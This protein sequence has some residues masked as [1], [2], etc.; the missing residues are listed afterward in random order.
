MSSD[1][2][3]F[4]VILPNY[5]LPNIGRAVQSILDQ[6]RADWELLVLCGGHH[7]GESTDDRLAGIPADPRIRRLTAVEPDAAA[8]V[9][10]AYHDARGQWI[11]GLD[12]DSHWYP[13]CLSAFADT[14][15][16]RPEAKFVFGDMDWE[17]NGRIQRAV[18]SDPNRPLT[19]AE[20]FRRGTPAGSASCYRRDAAIEL[21]GYTEAVRMCSDDFFLRICRRAPLYPV[22]R[23][24]CVRHG[25]D[26]QPRAA[27]DGRAAFA[28]VLERFAAGVPAAELDP[29]IVAGR[30]AGL[31]LSAGRQYLRGFEFARAQRVLR[32][33]LAAEW[34]IPGAALLRLAEAGARWFAAGRS[35]RRSLETA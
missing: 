22:G 17:R 10:R 15:Q 5:K 2:P 9:N 8:A 20:A 11:A 13:H 29:K 35:R 1:G 12:A 14:I 3:L 24:V 30:I 28:M 34:S 23:A 6:T 33:G 16:A 27:G 31:Y 4:S 7:R 25:T 32:R 18:S 26:E 19:L 21:G